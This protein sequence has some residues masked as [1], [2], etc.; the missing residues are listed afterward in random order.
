MLRA[1]YRALLI[2]RARSAA[3][4]VA[5]S[6]TANQLDDIGHDRWSL[7]DASVKRFTE[8]LNEAEVKRNN[9]AIR[10]PKKPSLL[11]NLWIIYKY[12]NFQ[13]PA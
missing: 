12:F 8:E 3:L 10:Y 6:M 2:G 13:R 9:K 11:K 7:I 4:K 1:I 5:R